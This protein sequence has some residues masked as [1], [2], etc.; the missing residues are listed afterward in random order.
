MTRM[1]FFMSL[2][3][4]FLTLAQRFSKPP[5]AARSAVSKHKSSGLRGALSSAFAFPGTGAWSGG[6]PET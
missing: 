1:T 5:L 2:S 3:S 4:L 6:K